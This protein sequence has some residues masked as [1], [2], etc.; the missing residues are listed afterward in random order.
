MGNIEVSQLFIILGTLVGCAFYSGVEIA[1]LTSNKLKIELDKKQGVFGASILSSLVGKPKLFLAMLLVGNNISL[2]IYGIV[3]GDV[4]TTMLESSFPS[5]NEVVG[6]YGV[7]I[8]QTIIST[9]VVLI[10]GEF[11]PKA[12]L[13]AQPNKWLLRL[14]PLIAIWYAIL[15]VFAYSVTKVSEWIISILFRNSPKEQDIVF[16]RTDLNH[17][18]EGFTGV[19]SQ[20]NELDLEIQFFQNALDFS[21]LK[22]RDCM[23]P[24]NE[25][26]AIDITE[27][28][29]KAKDLFIETKLSKIIVYRE[30]IDQLIGYVHFSDFF[31][32]PK[33][34]KEILR[35]IAIVPEPMA[36]NEIL[37][38]FR[39]QKKSVAAVVDEFGGT[40]GLI[41]FEDIIEEIFGEIEDE[42]DTIDNVERELKKG[43]YEFSGRLDVHYINE[44]YKLE[45]PENEEE[46]DTLGGLILN[47]HQDFPEVNQ[48]FVIDRFRFTILAVNERQ[49]KL[50]QLQNI[51]ES[52]NS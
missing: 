38:I 41:T 6:S 39:S 7:L 14:S 1:F 21:L 42:H 17:Y 5:L 48:E 22:A 27:S 31:K 19:N 50:V 13:S 24:R 4:L 43:V 12:L 29:A 40:S 30:N 10:F 51:E 28:I 35:P 11:I 52:T 37:K 47:F 20:Q 18:L 23:L 44:K 3:F 8:L 32:S 25:I 36:A 33:E 45:L 15:F 34:I 49:I 2:V 9:L 26:V 16:G 46:Y